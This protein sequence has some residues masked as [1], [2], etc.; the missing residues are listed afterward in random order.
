MVEQDV[1]GERVLVEVAVEHQL[2]VH[3]ACLSRREDR[4][5]TFLVQNCASR[6]MER[7]QPAMVRKTS[8]RANT[9]CN[10]KIL[11]ETHTH[12]RTHTQTHTLALR[13]CPDVDVPRGSEQLCLRAFL[14]VVRSTLHTN[15]ANQTCQLLRCSHELYKAS[16]T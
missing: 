5:V 13:A 16:V 1:Q 3:V 4:R 11:N 6:V 9:C 10:E 15:P 8:E 2:A 12:T 14:Q 7:A